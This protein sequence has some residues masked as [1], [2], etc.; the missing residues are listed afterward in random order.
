MCKSLWVIKS[1]RLHHPTPSQQQTSAWASV[2]TLD[3]HTRAPMYSQLSWAWASREWL[4]QPAAAVPGSVSPLAHV[5][6]APPDTWTRPG[7]ISFYWR[8]GPFGGQVKCQDQLWL[9]ARMVQVCGLSSIFFPLWSPL[10]QGRLVPRKSYGK[11]WGIKLGLNPEVRLGV[12]K[13]KKK[14]IWL[15][16]G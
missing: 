16:F 10:T 12:K 4:G 7:T 5:G 1:S 14:E 6:L 8:P 13:K 2:G 11:C 9:P 15:C 3:V